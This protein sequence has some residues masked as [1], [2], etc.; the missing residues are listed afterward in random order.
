MNPKL[1]ALVLVPAF[2]A[3][4]YFGTSAFFYRGGYD[5]PPQPEIP[6]L[7]L[8]TN[9]APDGP[10]LAPPIASAGEGLVIVDAQHGNSFTESEIV[11]LISKITERGYDVEFLGR[12]VAARSSAPQFPGRS[13]GSSPSPQSVAA[14]TLDER[15]R[16]ADSLLVILPG[17]PYS[18]AEAATVR[19]FVEKGGKLVLISDPSRSQQINTLAER[20]GLDFQP[21]YLYNLV[22][23]DQNFRNIFVRDFQPDELTAGLDTITLY[24]AGSIRSSGSGLASGDANT[25]SSLLGDS[26][27]LYP[28]AWGDSRSVLAIADFEFLVPP[29]NSLLD[30][31][32]LV[33]N[34]A[35]YLTS[36]E[37]EFDLADF[38]HFYERGQ[39]RGIDILLGRPG[40]WDIGLMVRVGLSDLGYSPTMSGVEDPSRDTVFLGLYEDA[41]QVDRYLQASGIRVGDTLGT[42]FAPDL[43]LA[44]TSI[45]VLDRSGDRDIIMVLADRPESL[46]GAVESLL[47]GKFRAELVSDFVGMRR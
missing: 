21:D 6:Y 16:G 42:P 25:R 3:A 7:D 20:F 1:A 44:G 4:A 39:D 45:T 43:E 9:L 29:Y 26:G 11:S 18:D 32:R 46:Y 38:P 40:L 10:L 24:T 23:N 31:G 5:A 34:L 12:L 37:R 33:S 2:A 30:N 8:T 35:D 28:I 27:D 14:Y 15:L 13:N 22:D 36:S 41:L 17:Q 47:S 19:R